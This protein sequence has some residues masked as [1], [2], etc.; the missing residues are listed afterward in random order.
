MNV[1]AA[2]A[3]TAR[4][5]SLTSEIYQA[6]QDAIPIISEIALALKVNTNLE[7]DGLRSRLASR[8]PLVAK[9]GFNS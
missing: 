3:A 2:I 9:Y 6:L 5:S 1:T 8:N 7:V 4:S